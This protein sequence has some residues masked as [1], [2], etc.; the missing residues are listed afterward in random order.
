[1]FKNGYKF[2]GSN[3]L[4]SL[5]KLII[6]FGFLTNSYFLIKAG[7]FDDNSVTIVTQS[8]AYVGLILSLLVWI[9]PIRQIS[10]IVLGLFCLSLIPASNFLEKHDIAILKTEAT[11]VFSSIYVLFAL[12][13]FSKSNINQNDFTKTDTDSTD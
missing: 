2:L 11:F 7:S 10:E 9:Q 4:T 1:M 8:V 12:L 13:L 6:C 5:I 3:R